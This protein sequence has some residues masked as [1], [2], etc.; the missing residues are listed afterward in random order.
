[1]PREY[2]WL[3]MLLAASCAA[4]ADQV[5]S[6]VGRIVDPGNAAIGRASLV[7]AER[8]NPDVHYEATT[9]S[10]GDFSFAGAVPGIYALTVEA[11]G[12]LDKTIS[13]INI[14]SGESRDLKTIALKLAGCFA[15]GIICDDFG[16]GAP[17]IHAAATIEIATNCGVD[18]D[19]GKT[20]CTARDSNSDF[21]V[22][23]GENGAAYLVPRNGAS[24]ARDSHGQWSLDD[25]VTAEYSGAEVRVDNLVLGIRVC[26]HANGGRYAEVHSI[27]KSDDGARVRM[28]FLTWPGKSDPH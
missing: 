26:V 4:G 9:N 7:L 14:T 24:V 1:M 18:V 15:P 27:R 12:F 19:T 25:C 16:L 10:S 8:S 6:V 21:G 13:N 28:T 22:R 20:T 11:P 17:F 23:L 5:G 3:F 2:C